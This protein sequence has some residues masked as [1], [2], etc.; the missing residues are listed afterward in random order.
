MAPPPERGGGFGSRLIGRL[1]KA[2]DG[3]VELDFRPEIDF[4]VAASAVR[5]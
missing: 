1:A 3:S 4:P 2:L 5:A